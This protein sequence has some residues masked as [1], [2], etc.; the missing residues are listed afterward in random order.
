M[1]GSH[2]TRRRRRLI[3][4]FLALL[5][6][7]GVSVALLGEGRHPLVLSGG[8]LSGEGQLR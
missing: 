4:A 7:C 2:S 6:L 5:V 8:L 1:D 3:E